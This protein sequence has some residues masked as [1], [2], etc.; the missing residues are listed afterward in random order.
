MKD[1][2]SVESSDYEEVLRLGQK[3]IESAP[4]IILGSG[5]SIAHNIRGMGPLAD[6]LIEKIAPDAGDVALWE[7]FKA[8]LTASRDLEKALQ[9]VTISD[10]LL[11]DVIHYTREMVLEDDLALFEQLVDGRMTLPLS[12]L[13]SHTLRSTH[14]TISVVTTNYDRVAEYAA[15][16]SHVR[17]NDGFSMGHYCEFRTS[18]DQ[19]SGSWR[20]KP[21]C[22]DIWKVHGS[23]DWFLGQNQSPLSLPHRTSYP[24]CIKPLLVTPG[25]RKYFQTHEEPFR[26]IITQADAALSS[27]QGFLC[28]GYG[29]SDTHI[30]PKLIK[31]SL[32]HKP[33]IVILARTLRDG[34]KAFINRCSH[35]KVLA[36]EKD[37][38]GTRAYTTG[39]RDGFV[40]PDKS[41]WDLRAFID[42]IGIPK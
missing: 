9:D 11:H 16:F 8:C 20:A 1:S 23:V 27:A 3:C 2:S 28:V 19:A 24:S 7:S 25:V 17:F 38:S 22:V 39:R 31:R 26:T 5:A 10:K 33:P 21:K 14:H 40:I 12:R 36:L 35:E 41:L 6:Y 37:G 32:D 42:A 34:A 13:F 30:E 29:F 4:V 15:D 18:L